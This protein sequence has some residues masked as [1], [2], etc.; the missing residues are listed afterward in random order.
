VEIRK[1]IINEK[2][3][4]KEVLL[5]DEEGKNLGIFPLE[6]ALKK[7]KEVDLD[8]I[9]VSPKARPPVCR[10]MDFGKFKYLQAKKEKKSKKAKSEL[11]EIRLTPKISTHDLE[12]KLKKIKEFLEEGQKVRIYVHFKGREIMFQER[13]KELINEIIKNLE[14]LGQK[15]GEPIFRGRR[16]SVIIT[17]KK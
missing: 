17:P 16:L 5:I 7:A 4:A 6:E 3:R 1:F 2:I 13:G 10:I 15:E 14:E 11:K 9:L 12:I 8:L